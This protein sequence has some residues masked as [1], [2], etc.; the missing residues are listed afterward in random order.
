MKGN[1]K[2]QIIIDFCMQQVCVNFEMKKKMSQCGE[3]TKKKVERI[4]ILSSET[5]TNH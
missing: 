4:G 3:S 5:N 1:Y 2:L